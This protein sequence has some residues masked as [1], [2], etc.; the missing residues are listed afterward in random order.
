MCITSSYG[1]ML[2]I[3]FQELNSIY[4]LS[5]KFQILLPGKPVGALKYLDFLL[6]RQNKS[7]RRSI[8]IKLQKIQFSK[9]KKMCIIGEE[10]KI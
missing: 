5:G 8:H 7:N 9:N 4:S 3:P 1:I 6:I 2:A 10:I